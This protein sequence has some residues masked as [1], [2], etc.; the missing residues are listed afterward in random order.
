MQSAFTDSGIRGHFERTF[1]CKIQEGDDVLVSC[2]S[3]AD[4]ATTTYFDNF[5]LKLHNASIPC[6]WRDH[7]LYEFRKH[8]MILNTIRFEDSRDSA[9]H[10]KDEVLSRLVRLP[11]FESLAD[12]TE[13]Y[14]VDFSL[15]ETHHVT[16]IITYSA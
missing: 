3:I 12:F 2:R 8:P 5:W 13:F 4:G 11:D 1:E 16:I 6:S 7:L 15:N 10:R 9:F 14:S